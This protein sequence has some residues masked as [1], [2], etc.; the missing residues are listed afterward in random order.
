MKTWLCAHAME[1]IFISLVV[2]EYYLLL[3][4]IIFVYR[5]YFIHCPSNIPARENNSF[6]GIFELLFRFQLLFFFFFFSLL[7]EI[8]D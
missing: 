3:S 4:K 6:S 1:V 2:V 5:A 7:L 8:D